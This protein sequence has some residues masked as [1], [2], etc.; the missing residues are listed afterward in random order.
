TSVKQCR[1][2]LMA[3]TVDLKAE[4]KCS[5]T[6]RMAALMGKEKPWPKAWKWASLWLCHDK[7]VSSANLCR[8]VLTALIVDLKAEEECSPTW[9]TAAHKMGKE[10]P[11]A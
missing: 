6:W 3:L 1:A 4:E 7:E 8:A 5:P 2:A 11:K 9:R 10:R